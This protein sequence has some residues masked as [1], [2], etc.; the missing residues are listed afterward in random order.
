MAQTSGWVGSGEYFMLKLQAEKEERKK[1]NNKKLSLIF[2]DLRVQEK[3]DIGEMRYK[4]KKKTS[5]TLPDPL[6]TFVILTKRATQ[7]S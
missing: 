6:S 4:I 3:L 1:N 2:A 5:V 7:R